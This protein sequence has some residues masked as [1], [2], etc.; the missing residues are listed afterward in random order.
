MIKFFRFKIYLAL[1]LIVF[2][3]VFGVLGYRYSTDYSWIDALYMT[4]ITVTTV[5]F[6]EVR[7][8][9]PE[10]KLFTILLIVTSVFIVG[11]VISVVTEHLLGRNPIQILK[12][13]ESKKTINSLSN[14]VVVC[15]F[16]RNGMQAS[17][18]LKAYNK[19]FI[20]HRT[21]KGNYR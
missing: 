19:P 15:G 1:V 6:S 14:H 10:G 17:E 9:G 11:F 18:R 13:K 20:I 21:R 12:K 4:I 7:P 2:V 16:G 8:M 5:G 3:L